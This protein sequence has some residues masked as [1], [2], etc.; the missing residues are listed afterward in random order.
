[1]LLQKRNSGPHLGRID[2]RIKVQSMR[3]ENLTGQWTTE[4]SA[5]MRR[6]AGSHHFS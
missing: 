3:F 4:A 5:Q 6:R 2:I 1:L